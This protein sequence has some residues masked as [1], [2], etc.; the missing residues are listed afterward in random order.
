MKFNTNRFFIDAVIIFF[1][2]M[3]LPLFAFQLY[4]QEM[5]FN[6]AWT[7]ALDDTIKNY[8]RG[9]HAGSDVDQDGKPEIIVTSY[10]NG[11]QIHVFEIIGNDMMQW[12]WS[13]SHG[14]NEGTLQ[15]RCVVVADMDRNGREEIITHISPIEIN[16]GNSENVGFYFWEWDGVSDNS[17]GT[18]GTP[19][20]ILPIWQIDSELTSTGI[21]ENFTIDDIDNDNEYELVWACDAPGSDNDAF[22]IFS[23]TNGAFESGSVSWNVEAKWRRKDAEI[24]GSPKCATIADMD[25]DG[26]KEAIGSIWNNGTLFIVESNGVDSY[27]NPI[28]LQTDDRLQDNVFFKIISSDND[29]NGRDEIYGIF[30]DSGD[31]V[32]VESGSDVSS[33]DMSNVHFLRRNIGTVGG[34]HCAVGDQNQNL[35]PNLY[36]TTYEG[37]GITDLEFQGGSI[38]DSSNY[39]LTTAFY[40]PYNNFNGSFAIAAPKNDLDRD[41][42]KELIVSMLEPQNDRWI[43]GLESIETPST[44]NITFLANTATVPDTL[45][46]NSVVQ[47]RG[48]V[49]PLSWDGNSQLFLKNIGG[50]YWEGSIEVNG[51]SEIAYYF[52]TNASHDTV[53]AGAEWE[54]E[55]WETIN[56]YI[57]DFVHPDGGARESS[58]TSYHQVSLNSILNGITIADLYSF[59]EIPS[60]ICDAVGK[61]SLFSLHTNAPD[62]RIVPFGD[63]GRSININGIRRAAEL[64]PNSEYYDQLVYFLYI[65]S[66]FHNNLLILVLLKLM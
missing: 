1:L 18:N 11:G 39:K 21:S 52:Y 35:K 32:C 62:G 49:S 54:N 64:C 59:I 33:I 48:N 26:Y 56:E 9:F 50:D 51:E 10:D 40:D 24:F 5:T 22:Y 20:Y 66:L 61:M 30:Y 29:N 19:T 42:M 57:E 28:N 27:Q 15:P 25:G 12:V 3:F 16:T 46:P 7:D 53:Y 2:V 14:I 55:G 6:V 45:G 65:Y 34:Y 60:I 8:V 36:F 17:F 41:G 63:S 47:V 37:G 58:S 13:S 43:V 4:S 38:S 44:V 23:L 31:I